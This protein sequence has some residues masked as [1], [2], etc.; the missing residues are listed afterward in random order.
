M[1]FDQ[2]E[3][4]PVESNPEIINSFIKK[5]GF[6]TNKY[7]FTDVLSTEDWAQAIVPQPC[8][9]VIFLYPISAKQLEYERQE[10]AKIRREG[11]T[12]SK[13]VS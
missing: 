2:N 1:Q 7:I 10:A 3:W 9:A 4:L 6:D 13:D 11:H 8:L 12:V 5:L